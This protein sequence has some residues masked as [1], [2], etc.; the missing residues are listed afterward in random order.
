MR[1]ASAVGL[2]LVPGAGS[3]R[4]SEVPSATR[5]KGGLARPF[6][7]TVAGQRRNLTGFASQRVCETPAYSKRVRLGHMKKLLGWVGMAFFLAMVTGGLWIPLVV[8]VFF[9]KHYDF[10]EVRVE[11]TVLP[12]GSLDITED[13]T[14]DFHNGPFHY[15]YF[16]VEEQ[17][18]DVRNFSVERVDADGS[19]TPVPADLS[20]SYYGQFRAQVNFPSVSDQ[21]VTY[22]F[23]YL[24]ACATQVYGDTAHLNWQLIGTGWEERTEHAHLIVNL[25]GHADG[26]F[27]RPATCEVLDGI[28]YDPEVNI[29]PPVVGAYLLSDGEAVANVHGPLNGTKEFRDPQQLVMDVSNVPAGD[30]VEA[31]ILFPSDAVPLAPPTITNP[32]SALRTVDHIRADEERWILEANTW[33][34]L[35]Y[36]QVRASKALAALLPFILIAAVALSRFRDRVPGIP[37]DLAE[38]PEADALEASFVWRKFAGSGTSS[39]SYRVQLLRLVRIGAVQLRTEGLVTDPKDITLVKVH[40]PEELSGSDAEFMKL[41]FGSSGEGDARDSVSIAHPKPIPP[42]GI[43]PGRYKNW[44]RAANGDD[45]SQRTLVT[46]EKSDARVESV[47]AFT[48][49]GITASYGFWSSAMAQ[50]GHVTMVLVPYALVLL[51]PAIV[52]IRGRLPFPL[53]ERVANLRAFRHFLLHFSSLPDAPAAGIVIWEQY[54]EWAVALGVAREVESQVRAIVPQQELTAPSWAG[55]GVVPSPTFLSSLTSVAHSATSAGS[56]SPPS[57]SGGYGSSSSS[58]GGGGF[59]GG[60]GGGGGGSGGGAG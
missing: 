1:R 58:S 54:M 19:T 8:D 2:V 57:T 30:F 42:G 25:P 10:N 17:G 26:R 37:R 41:L 5:R 27:E 55:T 38:P 44:L 39:D 36:Q 7:P 12:D 24:Y 16:T 28:E 14:F 23:H 11:A 3:P 33:R 9:T 51:V 13:R 18:Y 4:A 46:I 35:H 53:R 48:A 43:G 50:G 29:T 31:S 49:A 45:L 32:A 34:A 20:G 47:V 21:E 22:R 60:G 6:G 56:A 15:V 52:M 59:S 40:E